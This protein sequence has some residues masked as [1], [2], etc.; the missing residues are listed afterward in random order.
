MR[1]AVDTNALYTTR[2]GVARYTRELL[3]ALRRGPAPAGWVFEAFAWPVEN[4]GFRQPWRAW[5]TF[6]RECV[7]ARWTAPRRL[8]GEGFGLLHSTGN[9][10][11]V[12]PR[13]VRHVATVHDI[14]FLRYPERFRP[15]HRRMGIAAL[16]RSR[17]ADRVLCISAFT[18]DELVRLAG[19]DRGRLMVVHNG[20]S[21][22]RDVPPPQ[23][24]PGVL[25]DAFLL[26]VGSLEPGKNLG[27]L[28]EMYALAERDRVVLPDL[29]IVGARFQGLAGEGTPPRGW[30][31]LGH[32]PDASLVWLYRR[33]RALVFPSKY[34]GFGL[35]VAE[36]MTLGCPVVCSPV[37]S[38][39]EVAGPA[40]LMAEPDPRAYLRA[41]RRL[42]EEPGLRDECVALGLEQARRFS[43]DRCARETMD[44]YRQALGP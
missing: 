24:P 17:A 9:P 35:P 29:V 26:F 11:L 25:P 22:Q 1:I 21:F 28:R 37:S 23:A 5:R 42:L 6:R 39:P 36:A 34:E 10:L 12:P 13:G 15:W 19:F 32:L 44:V 30:H 43:W 18:A 16:E 8:R 2:A 14:G 38:L 3:A 4:F 7:W 31:Y 20:C 27:L 41:V 33:A 40:A